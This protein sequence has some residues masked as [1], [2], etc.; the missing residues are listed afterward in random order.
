M[1][2]LT[3]YKTSPED[4]YEE[5]IIVPKDNDLPVTVQAVNNDADETPYDFSGQT[6]K[7]EILEHSS[8]DT[9]LI[10]IADGSWTRDQSSEGATAGV[11]DKLK[12][13]IDWATMKPPTLELLFT[14]WWRIIV[15]D[16][17]GTDFTIARGP[18]MLED[19]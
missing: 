5:D 18:F 8:D 13:T 4:V 7:M 15:T 6:I 3:F 11:T 14:Y 1:S 12:T 10:T 19:K 9:A 16:A 17:V 2:T